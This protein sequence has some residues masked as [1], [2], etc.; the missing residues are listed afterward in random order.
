MPTNKATGQEIINLISTTGDRK[1][2]MMLQ[3]TTQE[4]IF[5]LFT[6]IIGCQ[7]AQTA[8]HRSKLLCRQIVHIIQRIVI[9]DFLR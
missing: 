6:I 4:I 7:F 5:N 3:S 2:M 8:V 1:H 9:N